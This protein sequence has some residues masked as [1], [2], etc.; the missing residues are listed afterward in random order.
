[1]KPGRRIWASNDVWAGG[2]DAAVASKLPMSAGNLADGRYRSVRPAPQ[3]DNYE[4]WVTSSRLDRAAA[5]RVY[6]INAE[7]VTAAGWPAAWQGG[8][9]DGIYDGTSH[10][11]V[12]DDIGGGPADEDWQSVGGRNWIVSPAGVPAVGF[13][14]PRMATDMVRRGVVDGSPGAATRPYFALT[15]AAW[16]TWPVGSPVGGWLDIDYGG[17]GANA[18]WVIGG[19]V[20]P[21]T[22]VIEVSS[23]TAVAFAPPGTPPAWGGALGVNV[24]AYTHHY[25]ADLYPDDPGNDE[26][27]ALSPTEASIS[28]D[29]QAD[30]WT[31]PIAHAMTTPPFDVG[32]SRMSGEWIAVMSDGDIARSTDG[33]VWV[34]DAAAIVGSMGAGIAT[35]TRITTDGYGHWM[36]LEIDNGGL[37]GPGFVT[38]IW[39]SHDDGASWYRVFEE[40]ELAA[41]WDGCIW[42]GRGQ[43]HIVLQENSTGIGTIHSTLR[44]VD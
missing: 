14:V 35:T 23:G 33:L 30:V 34:C 4:Q 26:W 42:Y 25:A 32:Y 24:V 15:G 12:S 19:D 3:T 7:P 16:A 44:A 41:V 28:V 6:T 22:P 38:K 2:P 9:C 21:W 37:G 29:G 1:M 8:W 20:G 10:S 17:I 13:V 18:R 40:L 31:A 36:L 11:V 27:L 39:A 43:F 5:M